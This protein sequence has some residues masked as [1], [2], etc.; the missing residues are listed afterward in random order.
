MSRIRFIN[1]SILGFII[2]FYLSVLIPKNPFEEIPSLCIFTVDKP[3]W[4]NC[5]LVL[6]SIYIWIVHKIY[7]DFFH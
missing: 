5:F 1:F 2:I 7:C 4:I 6:S 3:I